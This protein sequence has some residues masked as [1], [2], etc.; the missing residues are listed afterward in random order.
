[1]SRVESVRSALFGV[2]AVLLLV[3]LSALSG[4]GGP[5]QP[6]PI[7]HAQSSELTIVPGIFTLSEPLDPG[8]AMPELAEAAL[9]S[10]WTN[11][12]S[13]GF[14][15]DFP[16]SEWLRVPVPAAYVWGKRDCEAH[17]GSYSAMAHGGG[18][19]GSAAIC[20]TE[21]PPDI[22][23][24]W[25]IYGPFSLQG[26]TAAELTFWLK[27]NTTSE[28]D[29]LSYLAS[30]D[31]ETFY[32]M[33]VYGTTNGWESVDP[34]LDLG[35]IPGLGS[36]LGKDNVWIAF[37]F[38]SD[39]SG[40]GQGAFVDDVVVRAKG[41]GTL[42]HT[43]YLPALMG[44]RPLEQASRVVNT[45][46]SGTLTTTSGVSVTVPAG[47]VS[48]TVD[49]QV[50]AMTFSVD[51][52]VNTAPLPAGFTGLSNAYTFGPSGFNFSAP[53]KVSFP[54]PAGKDLRTVGVML[55]DEAS[56]T[57]KPA[58]S[59]T[60]AQKR[61]VSV[62]TQHF[63][64]FR[65]V[66]SES[67]RTQGRFYWSTQLGTGSNITGTWICVATAA[68]ESGASP[69]TVAWP[70]WSR[71]VPWSTDATWVENSL[72]KG[73]YTFYYRWGG[74]SSA[75]A[76]YAV[77]APVTLNS[78]TPSTVTLV[79]PPTSGAV[80]NGYPPCLGVPNNGQ[81]DYSAG[82][83][84]VQ[85]TLNWTDGVD[86]DLHVVEPSG[87]EIYYQHDRSGTNGQL[88]LDNKCENFV[89][90]RPENIYWPPAGSGGAPTGTYLIKVV[91]YDD[92]S[93]SPAEVPFSVRVII[94][95][96]VYTFRKTISTGSNPDS[97]MTVATCTKPSASSGDTPI[98]W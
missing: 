63:T 9:S 36:A 15:G 60:D 93:E 23:R 8:V 31:G 14:E 81:P 71:S 64:V 55:Y 89:S 40:S 67:F 61:T 33:T 62:E 68:L 77:S 79:V 24:D 10:T 92:C 59:T 75:D 73:T 29:Y 1:M 69:A 17:S 58:P 72:P 66:E 12:M 26:A 70:Q 30:T 28:N 25:L 41:T 87:E 82:T 74:A 45:N 50:G 11:V 43:A 13:E 86:L 51:E 27:L 85:V 95:G 20:G 80:L 57:W 21:Y 42:S 88:D 7:V 22:A 37:A 90:G 53:V 4:P 3:L 91:W 83:G 49:G 5:G 38:T 6:A 48:P 94:R 84:E 97:A 32:G 18:A 44:G 76:R 56:R 96:R 52:Y 34:V 54:V 78:S 35:S 65:P 2:A 39:G 19:T 98:C 47:A 46:Q 16:A